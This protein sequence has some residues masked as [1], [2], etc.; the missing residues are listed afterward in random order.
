M[1]EE[2]IVLDVVL[3]IVFVDMYVKLGMF[4]KVVEIFNRMKN[5]DVKFWI[6]MILVYGVYGL[7]RE[8]INFFYK[9]EVENSNVKFNDIIF[10]VVL[11]VCSY[12]GLVKEGII[13]FKRMIDIY[14]FIFEVEYYG[15]VVD[16]LG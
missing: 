15:C 4:D 1:E 6:V 2:K 7:V 11:N 3:G 10:L 14:R 13:C 8:V 16:F 5:K 9:M 12:G